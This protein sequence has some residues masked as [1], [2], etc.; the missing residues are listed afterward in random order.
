M[1]ENNG[2]RNY[3][4]TFCLVWERD[5]T[6][7]E[8]I[9]WDGIP[10][11]VRLQFAVETLRKDLRERSLRKVM[12]GE[13]WD[14]VEQ[15]RV[16]KSEERGCSRV[17]LFRSVKEPQMSSDWGWERVRCKDNWVERVAGWESFWVESIVMS[18][19]KWVKNSQTFFCWKY[20]CELLKMDKEHN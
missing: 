20:C 9:N 2:Q 5:W 12:T 15:W 13:R 19:W 17:L 8:W 18:Y 7:E 6:W 4:N 11:V 16:C 14:L 3:C 1:R 10:E